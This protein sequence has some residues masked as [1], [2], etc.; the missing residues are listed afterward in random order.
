M[1]G[2][3]FFACIHQKGN[4]VYLVEDKSLSTAEEMLPSESINSK[5]Q[6]FLL[7]RIEITQLLVN[8]PNCDKI[9]NFLK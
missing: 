8:I 7:V 9:Y 3:F 1:I 4:T 6:A 5:I 2:R